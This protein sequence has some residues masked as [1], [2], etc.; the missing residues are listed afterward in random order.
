MRQENEPLECPGG[1]RNE[2]SD[3]TD[4]QALNAQKSGVQLIIEH[5]I[6]CWVST[7]LYMNC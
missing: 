2:L 3:K 4:T 1:V 5:V 7:S 6:L